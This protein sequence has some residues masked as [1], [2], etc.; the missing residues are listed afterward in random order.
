MSTPEVPDESADAP[1]EAPRAPEDQIP[2]APPASA[3]GS[4]I[5]PE[6]APGTLDP[7]VNTPLPGAHRGGFTRAFTGP[8]GITIESAP[9]Q[10]G[11]EDG[12]DYT[13][14]EYVVPPPK[15]IYASWAL[16]FAIVGLAMALFIGWGFP[17]GVAAIVAAVIGLRRRENRSLCLWAIVLAGVSLV[18]SAGWLVWDATRPVLL[19]G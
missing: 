5:A 3:P 6:P 2:P 4:R 15:H 9:I 19:G 7:A 16:A 10:P 17:L 18:Y 13:P 12:I 11:S 14:A 1:A 8:V